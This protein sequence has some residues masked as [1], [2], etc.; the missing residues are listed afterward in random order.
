MR[1]ECDWSKNVVLKHFRWA[2]SKARFM[3]TAQEPQ[4]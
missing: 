3:I 1:N 2:H 4:Q